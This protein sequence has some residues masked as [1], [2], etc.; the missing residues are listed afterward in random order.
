[1]GP[2]RT[3]KLLARKRPRLVPI[4]DSVVKK[5]FQLKDSRGFWAGLRDAL[6]ENDNALHSHAL[7]LRD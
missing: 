2:M 3:S 5:E 1:M 7:A 6:R 4:Y